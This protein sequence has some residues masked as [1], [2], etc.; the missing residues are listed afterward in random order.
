M[1]LF[2]SCSLASAYIVV[3]SLAFFTVLILVFVLIS[4]P[5]PIA[6]LVIINPPI[7]QQRPTTRTSATRRTSRPQPLQ[8]TRLAKHTLAFRMCSNLNDLVAVGAA[9]ATDRAEDFLQGGRSVDVVSYE[10]GAGC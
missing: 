6:F 2:L 5:I 7:K 9:L 3:L 10:E 4:L 1:P 8:Q